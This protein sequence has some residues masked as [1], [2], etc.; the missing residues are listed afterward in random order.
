[1]GG[2]AKLKVTGRG[3]RLVGRIATNTDEGRKKEREERSSPSLTTE[4]RS[5]SSKRSSQKQNLTLEE[6]EVRTRWSRVL[7]TQLNLP[8]QRVWG[9]P[10]KN[11]LKGVPRVPVGKEGCRRPNKDAVA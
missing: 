6:V 3:V 8:H 11:S 5:P 2:E 1:L 9:Q 10:E 7:S 4:N